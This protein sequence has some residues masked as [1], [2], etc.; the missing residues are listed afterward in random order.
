MREGI[1]RQYN[2]INGIDKLVVTSIGNNAVEL[3]NRLTPEGLNGGDIQGN[4]LNAMFQLALQKAGAD[5]ISILV[6]DAIYDIGDKSN[7]L[8]VLATQRLETR[9][10][11]ILRLANENILTLIIKLESDFNGLYYPAIEPGR[12]IINQK[13]PYY[14]FIFGKPD[15]VNNYFSEEYVIGLT[16]YINH[17][18]LY[19]ID[20]NNISYQ[21][22]TYGIVGSA[23][24]SINKPNL[25]NRVSSDR[26][27]NFEFNVAVNFSALPFPDSYLMNVE[28]YQVTNNFRVSSIRKATEFPLY[29]APDSL[30]HTHVLTLTTTVNP[31]GNLEIILKNTVPAWISQTHTDNDADIEGDETTTF[32]FR[33]LTDGITNA[34]SN[35]SDQQYLAKM[36]LQLLR[37]R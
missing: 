37:S 30:G 11:F 7:P 32:G 3:T 23:I 34:Y 33:Y 20:E 26:H 21:A 10:Q 31:V 4:D 28:N 9:N 27:G 14:I 6:T 22:T 19:I 18:R 2:L 29:I 36:N 25:L 35:F 13:R 12:I 24:H 16:G 1:N 17:A 5:S 8:G 15:F